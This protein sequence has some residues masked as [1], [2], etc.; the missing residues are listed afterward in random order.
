MNFTPKTTHSHQIRMQSFSSGR[1][2]QHVLCATHY[3]LLCSLGPWWCLFIRLVC[4]DSN[5]L[6]TPTKQSRHSN[7][8]E[9]RRL[10]VFVSGDRHQIIQARSNITF[11]DLRDFAR[12]NTK[13]VTNVAKSRSH[14]S[15]QP[16][17]THKQT[18]IQRERERSLIVS[19]D[20]KK[21]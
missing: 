15:S 19:A 6:S 20:H 13:K 14:N 3:M 4:P 2:V 17:R 5:D 7:S 21:E 12:L 1:F 11:D 8:R 16:N 18:H 10:C 9:P